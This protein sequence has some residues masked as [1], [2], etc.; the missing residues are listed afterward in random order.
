ML[1]VQTSAHGEDR[2]WVK[3]IH[4]ISTRPPLTAQGRPDQIVYDTKQ[5]NINHLESYIINS[6]QDEINYYHS[7]FHYK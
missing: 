7:I 4:L 6:N 5:H 2:V 1:K 3:A